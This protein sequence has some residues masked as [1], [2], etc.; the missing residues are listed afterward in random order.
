MTTIGLEVTLG[1]KCLECGHTQE[2]VENEEWP[3]HCDHGMKLQP[4]RQIQLIE[5][6]KGE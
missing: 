5:D 6:G 2:T 1:W 3:F 4:Y